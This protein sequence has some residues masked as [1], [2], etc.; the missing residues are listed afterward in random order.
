MRR[1]LILWQ[2]L[3]KQG[4]WNRNSFK[5]IWKLRLPNEQYF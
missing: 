2:V 5:I 4:F 1:V 3:F